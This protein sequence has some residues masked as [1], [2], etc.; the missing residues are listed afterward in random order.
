MEKT[1]TSNTQH[2]TSNIERMLRRTHFVQ[3]WML[4]VGCWM[5]SSFLRVIGD[6]KSLLLPVD[7]DAVVDEQGQ[8]VL[9]VAGQVHNQ[10]LARFALVGTAAAA[11]GALLEHLPAVGRLEFPIGLEND[12]V[13]MAA[14]GFEED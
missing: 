3:G 12:Q 14:G 7:E 5:V 11:E 10:G 9:A 2:P 6:R 4:S 1:R 13:H 8:V